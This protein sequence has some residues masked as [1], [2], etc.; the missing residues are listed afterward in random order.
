MVDEAAQGLTGGAPGRFFSLFVP[1][2]RYFDRIAPPFEL[3]FALSSEVEPVP[4]EFLRFP[5][6]KPRR[7][8]HLFDNSDSAFWLY[9]QSLVLE[10]ASD[11]SEVEASQ[12]SQLL[13]LRLLLG[14][15]RAEL[16]Q[17]ELLEECEGTAQ[18]RVVL[19]SGAERPLW[20]SSLLSLRACRRR[21]RE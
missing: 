11:L 4:S 9:R 1:R 15:V 12:A 14:F 5:P 16:I 17:R 18:V 21:G 10:F 7:L 8:L 3:G 2:Y 6:P 13:A 20:Q 19:Y